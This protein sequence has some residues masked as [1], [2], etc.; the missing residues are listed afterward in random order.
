LH[1]VIKIVIDLKYPNL[2]TFK[3]NKKLNIKLKI[4]FQ[5]KFKLK[6]I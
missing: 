6:K 3:L 5:K 1:I 2:K 4:L